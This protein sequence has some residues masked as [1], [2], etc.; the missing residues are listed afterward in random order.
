MQGFLVRV[1]IVLGAILVGGVVLIGTL[2]NERFLWALLGPVGIGV[3]AAMIWTAY[4]NA[5]AK[6]KAMAAGAVDGIVCRHYQGLDISPNVTCEIWRFHDRLQINA[7]KERQTFNLSMDKVYYVKVTTHS[8]LRRVWRP[9]TRDLVD[10]WGRT[11]ASWRMGHTLQTERTNRAYHI[12]TIGYVASSGLPRDIRFRSE[13][14]L[15]RL[16]SFAS[17]VERLLPK[18]PKEGQER[19]V[20]L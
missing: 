14:N 16:N 18:H 19:V 4:G 17:Q 1:L 15:A 2:V 5:E 7:R 10:R 6:N 12:L 3:A 20:E 11:I 8:E 13:S 9:V